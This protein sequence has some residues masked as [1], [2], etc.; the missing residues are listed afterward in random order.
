MQQV[1]FRAA[2][3]TAG[4]HKPVAAACTIQ[5]EEFRVRFQT[6]ATLSVP[7]DAEGWSVDKVSCKLGENVAEW[8]SFSTTKTSWAL[9][10]FK[11]DAEAKGRSKKRKTQMIFGDQYAHSVAFPEED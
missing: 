1:V 4:P 11:G 8:T 2:E 6:P 10:L 5:G 3:M 7:A 9:I